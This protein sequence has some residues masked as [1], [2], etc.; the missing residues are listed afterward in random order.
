[1]PL[2]ARLLQVGHSNRNN[3]GNK[4][5]MSSMIYRIA[6]LI[7]QYQPQKAPYGVCKSRANM[8]WFLSLVP[9]KED[10]YERV[11]IFHLRSRDIDNIRVPVKFL[12]DNMQ[13]V[14]II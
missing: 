9:N 14:A 6:S 2:V 1:M 7:T 12:V 13:T 5:E 11:G 8:S 4:K 10:L 3:V